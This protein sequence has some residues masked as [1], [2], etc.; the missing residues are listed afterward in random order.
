MSFTLKIYGFHVRLRVEIPALVNNLDRTII[1]QYSQ[2]SDH[3]IRVLV[4]YDRQLL[5]IEMHMQYANL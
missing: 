2:L 3:V 4:S 5:I 1:L